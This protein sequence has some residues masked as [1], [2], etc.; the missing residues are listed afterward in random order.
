MLTASGGPFRG[1]DRDELADVTPGGRARAPDVA[2]GPEDHRR[3]RDAREQGARADRGALAVRRPVRADRGRRPPDVDRPRARALPRRR[4]ARARRASRHARPDLVRAHLPRAR[5]DAGPAARPRRGSTL[6]FE[7]PD[8]DAFPLLAL[9]RAGGRA[10]RDCAVRLQRGERGRR[11]GVPRRAHRVPRHRRDRRG[12]ARR[13]RRR[14]RRAT[15]TTWSPP[16]PRPARL[17]ARGLQP[18]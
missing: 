2:H 6:S 14:A 16:T 3:L 13:R 17:A 5:R 15:S 1:R 4:A 9:A 8:L 10:R 18:A 7:A 11:R 12:D